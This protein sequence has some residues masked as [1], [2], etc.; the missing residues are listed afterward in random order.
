PLRG[1]KK[2]AISDLFRFVF[3]A[4]KEPEAGKRLPRL[5]DHRRDEFLLMERLGIRER[6]DEETSEICS[7]CARCQLTSLR[8]GLRGG[9]ALANPVEVIPRQYYFLFQSGF[10]VRL[11]E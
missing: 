10:V 11:N 8:D 9:R 1:E 4:E 7:P 6:H 3:H 2:A 5:V